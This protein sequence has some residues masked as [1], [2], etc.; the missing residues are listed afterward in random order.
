MNTYV[1]KLVSLLLVLTMVLGCLG[2]NA[3]AAPAGTNSP[4]AS[5]YFALYGAKLIAPGGG[6]L[7]VA[8]NVEAMSTMSSIGMA[9]FRVYKADGT[10]V[11]TVIGSISNGMLQSQSDAYNGNYT[12]QASPGT[13]YYV[14]VTFTCSDAYGYDTR[15]YTTNTVIA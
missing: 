6:K 15:N 4:M 3:G 2:T 7:C 10:F 1:K 9:Y 13:T 11:T 5:N 14:V 8:G 12:Y